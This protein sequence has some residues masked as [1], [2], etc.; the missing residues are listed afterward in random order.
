MYQVG[1]GSND[2][3]NR[4]QRRQARQERRQDRREARQEGRAERRSARKEA[5]AKAKSRKAG[6]VFKT[7]ENS[8]PGPV[9]GPGDNPFRNVPSPDN[10]FKGMPDRGRPNRVP[11]FGSSPGFS[12]PGFIR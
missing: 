2:K 6:D 12:H 10:P 11:D 1:G 9:K 3:M 4:K 5:R 8:F 7:P